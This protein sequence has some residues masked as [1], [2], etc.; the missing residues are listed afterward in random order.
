M[1]AA[2]YQLAVEKER[3]ARAHFATCAACQD[4]TLY[5]ECGTPFYDAARKA[6]D[7][8]VATLAP[9]PERKRVHCKKCDS[10]GYIEERDQY[11]EYVTR[12]CEACGGSGGVW[13]DEL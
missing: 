6:M 7:E 12:D 10:Y 5:A 8:A 11:F 9:F 3:D 2:L 1:Y 13:E 4:A